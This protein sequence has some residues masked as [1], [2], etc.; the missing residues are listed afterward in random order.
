MFWG[1]MTFIIFHQQFLFGD[2]DETLKVDYYS[3][4]QHQNK[5]MTDLAQ[6]I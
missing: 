5:K 3:N 6:C 4:I 1:K 2:I